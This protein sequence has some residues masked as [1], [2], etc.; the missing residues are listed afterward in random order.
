MIKKGEKKKLNFFLKINFFSIFTINVSNK[1][2]ENG[3]EVRDEM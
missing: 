1:M 3:G 2:W